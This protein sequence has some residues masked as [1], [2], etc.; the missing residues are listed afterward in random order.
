MSKNPAES[1][2]SLQLAHLIKAICKRP[3][4]YVGDES[5][6][7]VAC[8]ISG[9]AYANESDRQTLT[10]FNRWVAAK[11][12]FPPNEVWSVGIARCIPDPDDIFEALPILF[13]EFLESGDVTPPSWLI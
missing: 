3:R 13:D 4:S 7:A 8:F 12:G 5:F 6:R 2:Q 10:Q 11:L 9:F 1:G